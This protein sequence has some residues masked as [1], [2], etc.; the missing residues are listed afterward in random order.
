MMEWGSD[1]GGILCFLRFFVA[2]HPVHP[3]NPCS[4]PHFPC[5][6]IPHSSF[7][8]PNWRAS[9]RPF[10]LSARVIFPLSLF[11][12]FAPFCGYPSCSR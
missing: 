2:I 9:L 10:A 8:I 5:L 6:S 12:I 1:G 3:V 11:A 7:L 4:I